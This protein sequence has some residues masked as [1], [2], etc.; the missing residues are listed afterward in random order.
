[1]QINK[2]QQHNQHEQTDTILNLYKAKKLNI[3]AA[4]INRMRRRDRGEGYV[5]VCVHL[6]RSE[7]DFLY[8][9]IYESLDEREREREKIR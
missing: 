4:R 8:H 5:C 2:K 9:N 6:A 7:I 3:M 1:M